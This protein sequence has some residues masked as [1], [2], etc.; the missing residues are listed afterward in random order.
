M[1]S[2]NQVG[3]E[4]VSL[5]D[6]QKTKPSFAREEMRP[7]AEKGLGSSTLH[8]SLAVRVTDVRSEVVGTLPPALEVLVKFVLL[9]EDSVP[10]ILRSLLSS[11]QFPMHTP[12]PPPP[13]PLAHDCQ[14]ASIYSG[15]KQA[16]CKGRELIYHYLRMS[17]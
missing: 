9:M 10:A 17:R 5:K 8:L 13:P 6:E 16:L 3:F 15:V 2:F 11:T 1:I 12:P 4:N 7:R 14:Q